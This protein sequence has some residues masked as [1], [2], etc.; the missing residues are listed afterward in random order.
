MEPKP[1]LADRNSDPMMASTRLREMIMGFRT[2][3]LLHVAAKLNLA[4]HLANGPQQAERL[5]QIAGADALSLR[6]VMRALGSLGLVVET[7]G[8]FELTAIGELLR[9]DTPGSLHAIALLYGEEWLW[10]AYGRM[11]HSVQ[12]GEPAFIQVHGMPFYEYLGQEPAAAAQF[13]QAMSEFSRL[14]AQAI[15]DAYEFVGYSTLV[16]VGVGRER[17]WPGCS[18]RTRVSPGCC[19]TC[20]TLSVGQTGSSPKPASAPG[21]RP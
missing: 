13:Q 20:Q 1:T 6:R 3:Q 19:S 17:C 7:D 2:T 9:R 10:R 8:T 18:R 5:A 15:A 12:T 14:E 4:D 11:V 16:D 21:P